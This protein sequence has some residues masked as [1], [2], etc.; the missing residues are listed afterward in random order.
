[1]KYGRCQ[2]TRALFGFETRCAL[3]SHEFLVSRFEPD[4]RLRKPQACSRP[5]TSSIDAPA[6]LL[7][8]VTAPNV[9]GG[10]FYPTLS[11]KD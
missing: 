3:T 1:M 4:V 5:H 8:T 6:A 11:N 10:L 7:C 9:L 2:L